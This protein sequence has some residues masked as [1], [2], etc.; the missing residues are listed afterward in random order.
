MQTSS[1]DLFTFQCTPYQIVVS[2]TDDALSAEVT[3]GDKKITFSSSQIRYGIGEEFPHSDLITKIHEVGADRIFSVAYP[4]TDPEEIWVFEAT[5]KTYQLIATGIEH[6]KASEY[7]MALDQFETAL[8][9]ARSVDPKSEERLLI[10]AIKAVN[11]KKILNSYK[12]LGRDF[13][14]EEAFAEFEEMISRHEKSD[15]LIEDLKWLSSLGKERPCELLLSAFINEEQN[16]LAEASL[17]YLELSR[18]NPKAANC[19]AKAYSLLEAVP[20]GMSTMM[21][22]A[23]RVAFEESL[24]L[25]NKSSSQKNAPTCFISFNVDEKG[26]GKWVSEVMTPDLT[27][28]GVKPLFCLWDLSLKA[29]LDKFQEFCRCA[30]GAIIVCTPALEEKCK[31]RKNS[32]MQLVEEVQV[33]KERFNDPDKASTTYP[34]YLKNSGKRS[35]FQ[36]YFQEVFGTKLPNSCSIF[37]CDNFDYF[38]AMLDLS[39]SL[40][41]LSKQERESVQKFFLGETR[42]ILEGKANKLKVSEWRESR[43]ERV[44]SMRNAIS[45][46]TSTFNKLVNLPMPPVNFTGREQQLKELHAM[47]KGNHR[48]SITGMGGLGK[49]ALSLEYANRNKDFY[50][51]VHFSRAETPQQLRSGL[52]KLAADLKLPKHENE[53][54]RLKRLKKT[55]EGLGKGCLLIFDGVDKPEVFDEIESLIPEKGSTVLITSR[56]S[57]KANDCNYQ[58]LSLEKFTVEEAS[59]YMRKVTGL[60]EDQYSKELISKLGQVPLAIKHAAMFIRQRKISYERYLEEFNSV[61]FDLFSKERV[62]NLPEKE[63]SVLKTWLVS[64]EEI[65]TV[66]MCPLA[67]EI[68]DFLS[69]L[70]QEP[71]P[72]K[73][74][75]SFCEKAFPES[76]QSVLDAVAYLIDYSLIDGTIPDQYQM[77]ALVQDVT[78]SQ[79][80][81]EK[82]ERFLSLASKTLGVYFRESNVKKLETRLKL[83]Q[84]TEHAETVL[85]NTIPSENPSEKF[86]DFDTLNAG[87]FN[88]YFDSGCYQN[89]LATVKS[90]VEIINK[91]LVVRNAFLIPA[92]GH[93]SACLS[94]LDRQ[95]ES[96]SYA[97]KALSLS[98]EKYGEKDS[99]TIDCFIV[100]GD[101]LGNLGRYEKSTTYL[102]NALSLARRSL[103][104]KN[105]TVASIFE[106]LGV[107]LRAAGRPKAALKH[108]QDSLEIKKDL[109]EGE[110]VDLARTYYYMG[111][112]LDD[113]GETEKA[114]SY[115]LKALNLE[116]ELLG[117]KH[118]DVAP[119]F[120]SV[121]DLLGKL[122]KNEE[123]LEYSQKELDLSIELWGEKHPRVA[124]SHSRMGYHLIELG[125][126]E[127][128]SEHQTKATNLCMEL[129]DPTHPIA[130]Y[131]YSCLAHRLRKLGL[132]EEALNSYLVILDQRKKY[133]GEN[134]PLIASTLE[135]IA[136]VLDEL[137]RQEE[138]Q[139]Y[140]AEALEL[141]KPEATFKRKV[142]KEQKDS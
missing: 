82:R 60:S 59:G 58:V 61:K 12:T 68:F 34:I 93:I 44:E 39:F 135:K 32:P 33:I 24:A 106:S 17:D 51:F 98:K 101:V 63:L 69:I 18:D 6:L 127:E 25:I 124:A 67:V 139:K 41:D 16:C 110:T 2:Q 120:G 35:S 55:L 30:N 47:C 22:D 94:Q 131:C 81:E 72:L 83:K 89:A 13:I 11:T 54:D 31:E 126:I 36:S 38:S 57:T 92:Y 28:A 109:Q 118:P 112:C 134:K 21:Q 80:S 75:E 64:L 19:V 125:K 45:K 14:D 119:S 95:E 99:G 15:D 91:L 9:I 107:N 140:R 122:E 49:T 4:K 104:D 71:V 96:L 8:K 87:L 43:E 138:A 114:L 7:E 123:A 130:A 121:A 23:V 79:M 116:E 117:E 102:L 86:E 76:D 77:H 46:H 56:L 105:F 53:V 90:Y 40:R 111:Q 1:K 10:S 115:S 26:A 142:N 29:N 52:L 97:L 141:N 27:I 62:K 48:I 73:F 129:L 133:D 128:S 65:K 113:L 42:K 37:P 74:I 20:N 100:V 50:H 5:K 108:L 137:G 3:N 78:K 84:L 66:H 85:S 103:G 88:Y 70:G 132:K 136:L